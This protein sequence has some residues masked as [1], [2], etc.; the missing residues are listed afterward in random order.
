MKF[1]QKHEFNL[2]RHTC[3][4]FVN[5][6]YKHERLCDVYTCTMCGYMHDVDTYILSCIVFTSRIPLL[7][8]FHSG[9]GLRY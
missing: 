2:N 4:F 5:T 1:H 9:V 7:P 8:L 3:V 6:W